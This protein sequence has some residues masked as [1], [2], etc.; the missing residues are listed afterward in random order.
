MLPADPSSQ[1]KSE[2][3]RALETPGVSPLAVLY[4]YCT[5]AV[6]R[7]NEPVLRFGATSDTVDV[8]RQPELGAG[9]L[10]DRPLVFANACTTLAADPYFTNELA[11]TFFDRGCR[12]FL[13]TE[14][15][16]PIQLAS[17]FAYLF[18]QFFTRQVAP[19][20]VAA[21]EA[22]SQARLFLWR[23]YRNVGGLFY[24]YVNQYELFLASDDEVVALRE[25]R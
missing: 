19:E 2:I 21:G 9:E 10:V 17:R 15:R 3:V 6:G 14:A 13:G 22:V 5:C 11:M 23:Y 12:A 20:P 16:V 4:L 25:H 1:P 18:F 24:S 8:I 7:G